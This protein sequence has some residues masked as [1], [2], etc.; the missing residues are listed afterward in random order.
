M[1]QGNQSI[2]METVIDLVSL[3]T[4]GNAESVDTSTP[5][6]MMDEVKKITYN[7]YLQIIFFLSFILITFYHSVM[8]LGQMWSFLKSE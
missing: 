2:V 3:G 7:I 8:M 5:E 4:H 1:T 6:A